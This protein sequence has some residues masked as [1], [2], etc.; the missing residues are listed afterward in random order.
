MAKPNTSGSLLKTFTS[1][2]PSRNLAKAPSKALLQI[3]GGLGT[4][5][6]SVVESLPGCAD[7]AFLAY[8]GADPVF[9]YATQGDPVGHRPTSAFCHKNMSIIRHLFSLW[10]TE[11][12]ELYRIFFAWIRE[13]SVKEISAEVLYRRT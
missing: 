1:L 11:D 2:A 10:A 3:F 6:V 8:C 13:R 5:E 9:N 12:P 4:A 7:C